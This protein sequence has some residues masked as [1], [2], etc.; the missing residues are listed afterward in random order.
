MHD[1]PRPNTPAWPGPYE[2][3][4]T[5]SLLNRYLE[6]PY[7]FYIY[8]VLGLEEPAE[9]HP[10]LVWGDTFHRALEEVINSDILISEMDETYLADIDQVIHE[11]ISDKWPSAPS[12]YEHTVRHMYRL[13]DD[14]YKANGNW[15]A[16]VEINQEYTTYNGYKVKVRGKV[17]GM[18]ETHIAEHK[19]KGKLDTD[20]ARLETPVDLQTT[21]YCKMTERYN[22]IYDVIRIPEAQFFSPQRNLGESWSSWARRIFHTYTGS[23]QDYPI[24][25]RR[26]LWLDQ[27]TIYHTPED[28]DRNCRYLVDPN[29]EKLCRWWDRVNEPGFDPNDYTKY[30]DIFYMKPV[31]TFDPSRTEKFK[32]NYH[33]LLCNAEGIDYLRPTKFYAELADEEA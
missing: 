7:R 24:A 5:Q 30:D 17:D 12:S 19:C 20:Q 8:A 10:N 33:S 1:L 9:A 15:E 29:I 22:I 23:S 31:R 32:C 25:K 21:L 28:I 14:S 6:C 3:G 13:Y 4:V 11:H 27:F 2:G 26:H 16:E 18:S